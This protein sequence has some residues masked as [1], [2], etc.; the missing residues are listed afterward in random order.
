MTA[1]DISGSC[2]LRF[3]AGLALCFALAAPGF[4]QQGYPSKPVKFITGVPPG[5][6]SDFVSRLIAEG[7]TVSLGQPVVVENR[8]GGGTTIGQAAVATAAPD[9]YTIGLISNAPTTAAPLLQKL[10]YEP[11]GFTPIALVADVPLM[12]LVQP[13]MGVKT[14][15]ELVARVKASPGKFNYA[16]DGVGSSTHLGFELLKIRAGSLDVTHI[17]FKG[18]AEILMGYG[19]NDVQMS[20]T[21]V[22]AALGTVRDGRIQALAITGPNR[23]PALPDVPTMKE[24]DV[25]ALRGVNLS[26]WFAVAGPAGL[27]A[28]IQ[29]RLYRDIVAYL[30]KPEVKTRMESAGG[31]TVLTGSPQDLSRLISDSTAQWKETIEKANIRIQ[32]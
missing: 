14:L 1:G 10:P 26:S 8:P 13:S 20:I 21:G 31:L 15:G 12:V 19:S 23:L 18:T 17:P 32:N 24:A 30:S 28:D 11:T 4:A 27:P 2:G 7:L 6:P 3:V 29:I 5:G 9:G 25:P 16:S 22:Q